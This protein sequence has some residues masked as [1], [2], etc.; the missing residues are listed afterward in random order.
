MKLKIAKITKIK[1]LQ[2]LAII[3][4]IALIFIAVKPIWAQNQ[5]SST[6]Q[7]DQL[8][9]ITL[10]Q[11]KYK[12]LKVVAGEAKGILSNTITIN[13]PNGSVS[14]QITDKTEILVENDNKKITLN[15][16]N[17]GD[18]LI[19]IG[20]INVGKVIVA[21]KL[22]IAS[23][24]KPKKTKKLIIGQ[25]IEFDENKLY[26]YDPNS[27]SWPIINYTKDA[28]ILNQDNN[29]LDVKEIKKADL[30]IAIT[31]ISQEKDQQI[32]ILE[33]ASVITA[34]EELIKNLPKGTQS[35]TISAKI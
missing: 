1:P 31:N 18:Y 26:L 34:F 13:T 12:R 3:L 15:D 29:N 20:Q 28:K 11:L 22:R 17:I 32:L 27:K 6:S 10:E 16:I 4:F 24:Q 25:L 9:K 19:A 14:I 2:A 5:A 23:D 21:E 8:K 33:K 30:V 35:A 7:L